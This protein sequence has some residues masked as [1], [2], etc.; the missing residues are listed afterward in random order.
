MLLV[1]AVFYT[2]TAQEYPKGH[3]I[4]IGGGERPKPV[5]QKFIELAGGTNARIIV[6][7]MATALAEQTGA[8][9]SAEMLGLGASTAGYLNITREQAESDSV[10]MAIRSATGIF[11]SGG[12]QSRLTAVL[13]NTKA[14]RALHELYQSGGVLGGT[15]AGAAVMSA[16]MIT[17][18]ELR[19]HRDSS[20]NIIERGNI[21]TAD[22]FG[23]VTEAIIDQHF[24]IRKRYNRLFSL[25]A[26]NPRLIGVGIDEETAIH[27]KPDRTFEVLGERVV[28]VM[29][30]RDAEL[31]LPPDTY[32]M[33]ARGINIDILRRG[34]RYDLKKGITLELSR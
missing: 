3:L 22:G 5:M 9:Q 21:G 28:V 18:D 8:R 29:D 20:F 14:E 10:A 13:K 24:A 6:L 7:P 25:V 31:N 4:I 32:G 12:D 23:F 1:F 27:V 30:A 11:F 2:A 15:S 34:A 17:G 26:E 33:E 16:V 19:P